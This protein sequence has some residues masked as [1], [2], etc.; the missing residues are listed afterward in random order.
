MCDAVRAAQPQDM[1]E[2]GSCVV[3]SAAQLPCSKVIHAVGP[4]FFEGLT[5]YTVLHNS[6]IKPTS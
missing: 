4:N 2:V 3:T 6:S 1:V 5:L